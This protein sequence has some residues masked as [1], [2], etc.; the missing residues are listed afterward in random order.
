M[1][2]RA[3]IEI[4][5]NKMFFTSEDTLIVYVGDNKL[6]ISEFDIISVLNRF[7]EIVTASVNS[8]KYLDDVNCL[9]IKFETNDTEFMDKVPV[10]IYV[11][12]Y[13]GRNK[14]ISL[15]PY[16]HIECNL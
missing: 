11:N 10:C 15:L 3:K 2:G 16:G 4:V 6:D 5:T 1:E 13:K 12:L 14:K 8:S 9:V 7:G